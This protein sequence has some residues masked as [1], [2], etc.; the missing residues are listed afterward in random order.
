MLG[1]SFCPLQKAKGIVK[2]MSSSLSFEERVRARMDVIRSQKEIDYV[3][4]EARRRLK[5]EKKEKKQPAFRAILERAAEEKK[6]QQ[7]KYMSILDMEVRM[8]KLEYE[9]EQEVYEYK[10]NMIYTEHTME[11]KKGYEE[12]F[13]EKLGKLHDEQTRYVQMKYRYWIE[14]MEM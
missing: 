3:E 11:E 12:R 5:A 1:G 13:R 6:K 14:M 9:I 4:N 2:R 7:Q 10:K 8:K